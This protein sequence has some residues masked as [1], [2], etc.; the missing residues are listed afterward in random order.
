[1]GSVLGIGSNLGDS[2][3]HDSPSDRLQD[4]RYD[5]RFATLPWGCIGDGYDLFI[6]S[7]AKYARMVST[8]YP[9]GNRRNAI[10]SPDVPF[11]ITRTERSHRLPPRPF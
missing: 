11:Q 6:D 2:Y 10:H 1:M 8:I 7:P 3:S 5:R 9:D 4:K